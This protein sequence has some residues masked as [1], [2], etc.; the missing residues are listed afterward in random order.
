MHYY[1]CVTQLAVVTCVLSEN[2]DF[3][4]STEITHRRLASLFD[5][6]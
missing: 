1:H 6:A 5:I 2:A 3:D 4:N